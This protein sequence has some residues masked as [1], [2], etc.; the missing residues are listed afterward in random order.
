MEIIYNRYYRILFIFSL[1]VE[2]IKIVY[3][4]SLFSI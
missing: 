1:R 3:N 2:V 4:G